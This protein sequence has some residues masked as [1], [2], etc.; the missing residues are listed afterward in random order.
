MEN[1]LAQLVALLIFF[2]SHFI[3]VGGWIFIYE[4]VFK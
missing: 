2:A 1:Y 4:A 3:V